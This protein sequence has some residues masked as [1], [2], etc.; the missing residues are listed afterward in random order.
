MD[1]RQQRNSLQDEVDKLEM[2]AQDDHTH[3][4][5]TKQEN[6]KLK[7]KIATMEKEMEQNQKKYI[8]DAVKN[9]NLKVLSMTQRNV[10]LEDEVMTKGIEILK[11]TNVIQDLEE[12]DNNSKPIMAHSLQEELNFGDK[13]ESDLKKK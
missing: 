7:E 11:L 13:K 8:D 6:I 10:D 9:L 1:L 12:K 4:I 5:K 3:M 2:D